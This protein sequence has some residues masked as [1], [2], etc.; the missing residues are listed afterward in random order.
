[1]SRHEWEQAPSLLR[2]RRKPMRIRLSMALAVTAASVL[3]VGTSAA[4]AAT[5]GHG[6][7]AVIA[8]TVPVSGP[9]PLRALAAGSR[10]RLS[11]FVGRD[12]AGLAAAAAA[13]SDPAS[14]GYGHYLSPAQVQARFGATAAQQT[15]VRGWLS[16]SGLTVTHDDGFVITAMGTAARA[17]AALQTGLALSLRAGGAGQVVPSRALSVP[18]AVA[19]AITTIRVSTAVVPLSPHQPLNG[20]RRDGAWLGDGGRVRRAVLGLLRAE[21]GRGPA[22][23]LR[24]DA[25]LGAVRLP[26]RPAARR[27]RGGRVRA[28]RG[29]GER[30]GHQRDRR[31]DGAQRRQPLGP[32]AARPAVRPWPVQGVHRAGC[33][34][35]RHNRGRPRHRGRARDGP[36]RQGRLRVRRRP[37]HRRPAA[38]RAGHG[39]TASPGRRGDELVVRDQHAVSRQHGHVMGERA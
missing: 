9:G 39:G 25:H 10:V 5:Q 33:G 29:R 21:E 16:R 26:A 34:W 32:A 14:P 15:A 6:G 36:G 19:G 24:P 37:D 27:L 7:R 18:V 17:E 12:Q 2:K 20:G 8:S 31:P 28:H 22:Q 11:V 30:G 4:G 1:M 13:I 23:G 38:R 35:R 3:V